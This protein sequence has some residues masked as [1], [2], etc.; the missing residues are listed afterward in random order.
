MHLRRKALQVNT[1]LE[2]LLSGSNMYKSVTHHDD[3]IAKHP[4]IW[5]NLLDK[6]IKTSKKKGWI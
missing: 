2:R 4:A 5:D 3:F 1:A 6:K